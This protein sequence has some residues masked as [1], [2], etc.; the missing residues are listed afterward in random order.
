MYQGYKIAIVV[1]AYNEADLIA[2][3]LSG[4]PD[5]A[6]R[7][8]A[9]DDGS[10]DDTHQIMKRFSSER[11][12]IL[13]NGRNGGVGAAIAT[14]YKKAVEEHMDI[15]AVMAGDNQ[16]DP[17]HLTTLLNALITD[18][19]DYVKGT[20]LTQLNHRKGMSN[21]RFFGNWLLTMLTKI[22]SGYWKIR[23]PQNGYTAVTRETLMRIDP[24][25]I[26]P[27]Y[28]Y[29]NDM[30]IK[31]NTAGCKVVD[32]PIPARYGKEKSKIRYS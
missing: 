2:D 27:R 29:C 6:D 12:C 32:V 10:T 28:G 26:Y 21:W 5:I 8:Y 11:F 19:V 15:V 20:R 1:P 18:K 9:V 4:M 17:Q 7:V 25:K 16:M 22:A 3:T 23:D 14:G 31:L 13:S 30:L 24:E